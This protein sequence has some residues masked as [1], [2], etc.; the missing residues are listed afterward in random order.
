METE[1]DLSSA[2][3]EQEGGAGGCKMEGIVRGK[4]KNVVDFCR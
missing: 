4:E 2:R 1:V 3:G